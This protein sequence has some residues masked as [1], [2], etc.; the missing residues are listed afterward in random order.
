[1][2]DWLSTNLLLKKC[3]TWFWH[4]SIIHPRSGGTEGIHVEVLLVKRIVLREHI[5]FFKKTIDSPTNIPLTTI[6]ITCITLESIIRHSRGSCQPPWQFILYSIECWFKFCFCSIGIGFPPIHFSLFY[7][8]KIPIKFKSVHDVLLW[9]W[10]HYKAI[11]WD[12]Q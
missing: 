4:R 12:C 11:E 5:L 8:W 1:M 9:K 10:D 3:L 6:S 7:P 2:I